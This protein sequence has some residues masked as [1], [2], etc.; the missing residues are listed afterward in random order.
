MASSLSGDTINPDGVTNRH[1]ASCAALHF[2]D[3]IILGVS[4]RHCAL[5]AAPPSTSHGVTIRHCVPHAASSSQT[6]D[7]TTASAYARLLQ[8]AIA[9]STARTSRSITGMLMP[10][11]NSSQPSRASD[12]CSLFDSGASH[13]VEPNDFGAIAGSFRHDVKRLR[14]GDNRFM[15]VV[16]SVEKAFIPPADVGGPDIIRRVLIAPGVLCRVWSGASEVDTYHSTVVDSPSGSH[17]TLLDGRTI[18]LTKDRNGLRRAPSRIRPSDAS[19]CMVI[20][21]GLAPP[22]TP[23]LS[24][25]VDEL[26]LVRDVHETLT[27]NDFGNVPT[28]TCFDGY[29]TFVSGVGK[30]VVALTVL[31]HLRLWH[32][33]LC[34]PPTRR[35]LL[36]LQQLNVPGPVITREGLRQFNC[37]ACGM[38]DAF[39][40]RTRAINPAPRR[41]RD[42]A[43]KAA[44]A[45]SPRRALRPLRRL[46]IDIFGKVRYRSIQHHYQYLLGICDEATGYRWVFGCKEHTAEV[47]EELLQRFRAA[48][49]LILGDVDIIRSD[50]ASEFAKSERWK[51]FLSDCGIFPEYS[52]AYDARAMG[53]IE[54]TWKPMAPTA[55]IL[56]A[57]LGAGMGHWFTASCHAVFV[58]CALP[59]DVTTI[60]MVKQTSSA[61]KRL[62]Q[63]EIQPLNLRVYG[64]RVR[65]VLDPVQRDSKFA[66][67]ARGGMYVGISP[68][69]ASAMWVWDGA[70]HV[71]VD[72]CSVVDESPYIQQLVAPAE[73]LPDWPQPSIDDPPPAAD[74]VAAPKRVTRIVQ[75]AFPDGT[76]LTF[77]YMDKNNDRLWWPCTV[78]ESRVVESSGRR[79]HYVRWDD[80]G[81]W[82]QEQWIDLASP[83]RVWRV[84]NPP[85]AAAPAAS[86]PAIDR[87]ARDTTVRARAPAPAA[88]AP[89]APAAARQPAA[90]AAAAPVAAPPPAPAARPPAAPAAAAPVAA[91]SPAPAALAAPPAVP[92]LPAAL[93]PPSRRSSRG[94]PRYAMRRRATAA[95][96]LNEPSVAFCLNERA[97]AITCLLAAC[98]THQD[99][100]TPALLR[101]AA[102]LD[103]TTSDNTHCEGIDPATGSELD[104]TPA[105]ACDGS[106]VDRPDAAAKLAVACAHGNDNYTQLDACTI[107]ELQRC[108]EVYVFD[109]D[110]S[111][112][113]HPA[114]AAVKARPITT[115]RKTVVYYTEDGVARAIEP[116]SVAEAIRSLQADQWINAIHVELENLKSHSAYHLVPES[117]PLSKGKKIMRMTFVFK[118]KV[119]E[120]LSLEKFK[121]RLCVVG[122]GMQQGSDYWESYAACAR[123]SS[124]KLVIITTTVADWIDFHFDLWGA[125]LTAAIDTDVYTYQ[126]PGIEPETGPNGEKMVW[127]LDKAIYGTVQ[128]ARLFALKLRQA[129]FDI[130]FEVSMDDDNVL[131]LDHRLG[132]IILATHIDDGIG[133]ASTQAVL[134]YFYAELHK[135][136]FKFST[137]P[138]PWTTVLGFGVAR[139][140]TRRT[141]TITSRKHV[142]SLVKEHLGDAAR[143]DNPRTPS[144]PEFHDLVPPPVETDEQAAALSDMRTRARSLKGALIYV[145][146]VQPGISHA[147]SRVCSLMAKPTER[148][149]A[150]AK[151]ILAWLSHRADLGVTYGGPDMIGLESLLPKGAPA[152]PMSPTRDFS[153]TCTVD[154][155]LNGRGLPKAT[156][157]EAAATPPDRASSRSQLGYELSLAGGCFANSSKRQHSTAT[158]TAAAELFAASSA[159]ACI[160]SV[161]GVLRFISFGILGHEPVPLWCDNEVA[162]MV[163]RDASSIKRLAY[164]ARR[165]R[166]LQELH[167]RGVVHMPPEGVRGVVNPADAFTKHLDKHTFITF[168]QRI[169]NCAPGAI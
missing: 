58:G 92:A 165:V 102:D 28:L 112:S 126:P 62:F 70:A 43:F 169:Y 29:F 143:I 115:S 65:F 114:V 91:P 63:R 17:F 30:A 2:A 151:H 68:A 10:L 26:A 120:S 79:E 27:R 111:P 130:G 148:S 34:H 144:T 20:T 94:Q 50:N 72:G 59:G 107:H 93:P 135:R 85:P 9:S 32:C 147:V 150:C 156:P 77:G 122:S 36:A 39:K 168:M 75:D 82:G 155:D 88:A 101:E 31:E 38:C 44:T 145:A 61:H 132:R 13:F 14:V 16:G 22:F 153:L 124:V 118:V 46:L 146:Q 113:V 3:L 53:A 25:L 35:L 48:H 161:A 117:E 140:R 133:G 78:M 139:D 86:R 87:P 99:P 52:V 18:I 83:V 60:D 55:G 95:S 69:N 1:C 89:A 98:I 74:A 42:D 5:C 73:R 19:C 157:D 12:H 23:P 81:N 11:P 106:P 109:I 8:L 142:A 49:R 41:T 56:L 125:F 164:I 163:A 57:Q 138:G 80:A 84:I 160:I 24:S 100:L 54:V 6:I 33:R 40:Q 131:R 154:S 76:R 45:P 110:D 67:R 51:C 134:D 123:T 158:D 37:E 152:Q 47:I 166:L 7:S 167:A 90:P 64:A 96:L 66:E 141:V 105:D 128:A 15:P 129:L 119:S 108:G 137:E 103:L 104:A 21:S 97:A 162:V 136:D 71:T 149:Y 127:K 159:A 4:N 121:A 116:K